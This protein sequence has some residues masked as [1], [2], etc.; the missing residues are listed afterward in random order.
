MFAQVPFFTGAKLRKVRGGGGGTSIGFREELR[1]VRG[2]ECEDTEGAS[3]RKARGFGKL[4]C[5]QELMGKSFCFR[6][7]ETEGLQGAKE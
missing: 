1:S 4:R 5:D 2:Y 7:E 3:V 6:R